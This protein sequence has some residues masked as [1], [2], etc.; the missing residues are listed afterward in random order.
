MKSKQTIQDIK[1]GVY[2]IVSP[3]NRRYVGSSIHI[4]DRW[5]RYKKLK[6]KTQ[7]LL[8]RS[9]KK[10]GFDAHEFYILYE[11]QACDRLFWERMFGNIYLALN[12]FGGLNS[13]LPRADEMPQAF[14]KS[15]RE[16][17]SN[18]LKKFYLENPDIKKS[19]SERI[20]K[21]GK[22]EKCREN[23]KKAFSK[24]EYRKKRSEIAKEIFSRP[25]M[26][27]LNRSRMV[28]R[29]SNP[30]E[31]KKQSERITNYFKNNPS[32][33]QANRDRGIKRFEDP[34][35]RRLAAEKTIAYFKNNP[36]AGKAHSDRLKE[37]FKNG[38]KI[39]CSQEVVNVK[40]GEVYR[41][42]KSAAQSIGMNDRTLRDQ[43][44]G[45]Y[46]NKTYFVIYEPNK[47]AA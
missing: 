43:L 16:K 15:M 18:S 17:V 6:C 41:T 40:T 32:A 10:H 12:D 29:F 20:S 3:T 28:K 4:Y 44:R 37:Y 36:E 25:D 47:I 11:C 9:L 19:V 7:P 35:K 30:E 21:E 45:R 14:S 13:N 34:E 31:V 23:L 24:P 22:T 5:D 38:G 39:S 33:V 26:I 1:C 27:D 8:Y 2:L 46:P 42:I